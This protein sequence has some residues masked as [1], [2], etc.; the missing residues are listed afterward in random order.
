MASAFDFTNVSI[1]EM[2]IGMTVFVLIGINIRPDAYYVCTN[3]TCIGL[4]NRI[5]H[6]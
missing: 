1:L 6:S 4:M 2:W 5:A 3:N